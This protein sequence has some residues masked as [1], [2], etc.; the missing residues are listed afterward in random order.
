VD[1]E[2]NR[3]KV[4]RLQG[5]CY[6]LGSCSGA[7]FPENRFNVKLHSVQRN[8]QLP[9]NYLIGKPL[10]NPFQHI[11]FARRQQFLNITF[12]EGDKAWFCRGGKGTDN[13]AATRAM[14]RLSD[15]RWP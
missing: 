14:R 11:E 15:A 2:L 10:Y 6:G 8:A 9:R 7:E 5:L 3:L 4:A 1:L 13:P 12:I